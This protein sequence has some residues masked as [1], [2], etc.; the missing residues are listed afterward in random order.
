MGNAGRVW[1]KLPA[2]LVETMRRHDIDLDDLVADQLGNIVR[3]SENNSGLPGPAG[4]VDSPCA[5]RTPCRQA[6]D[7]FV[8]TERLE[9]DAQG[10]GRSPGDFDD[11]VDR[12]DD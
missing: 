8:H 7:Q 3:T 5:E 6:G 1:V 11:R 9:G 12:G 4:C 10:R 2:E